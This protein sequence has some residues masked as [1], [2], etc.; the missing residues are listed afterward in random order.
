M[1]ICV[2][3]LFRNVGWHDRVSYS[4]DY[5]KRALG[6]DQRCCRKPTYY[7]P[8]KR[9]KNGF[10]LQPGASVFSQVLSW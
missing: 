9:E 5:K 3:S 4:Y 7:E 10:L 8:C 2:R 1:S 6:S